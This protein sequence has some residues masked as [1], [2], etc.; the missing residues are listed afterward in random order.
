MKNI[1][2]GFLFFCL[3]FSQTLA[4]AK[5]TSQS[6]ASPLRRS[7]AQKNNAFAVDLYKK[8]A[9]KGGN[10]FFSP[11]SIYDALAM[12]F[13]G[14]RGRTEA[15]MARVLHITSP[16]EVFHPAFSSL[17]NVI[18]A[19]P[20]EKAY[21]LH[22][23]NALWG[24]KGYR[25]LP[26][27]LTLVNK[28]YD[29]GFH[30]VDFV[31][32]KAGTMKRINRWVEK[33]T[34][35]KIKDLIRN[36]DINFL[37]RLVLTNAIYF[38]GRWATRFKK[39]NTRSA[40]FYLSGGEKTDVPMMSQKGRFPYFE[41]KSLQVLELP[42]TGNDLSMVIFL[43]KNPVNLRKIGT[44]LSVSKLRTFLSRLQ[45]RRVAVTLPRFRLK[46]RY[47]LGPI[48]GSMGMPNAFSPVADFSGMSGNKELKIAKV[49][50]QAYV[51]VNE[52]G[53]EAAA[54]TAVVIRLKAMIRNPVFRADHPFLF[55]MIHKKTNCILFMGRVMNPTK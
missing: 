42:Y 23:A 30:L 18:K 10:I 24:Q 49:I 29:G 50:H 51:D 43:P 16:Q 34:G 26:N 14:A 37:T 39:E 52:E 1:I 11:F 5:T 12:T 38:K 35:N 20:V 25:F 41:D 36:G 47:Y 45:K 40:P 6:Q 22:I 21:K 27:F 13:A 44:Q 3:I 53:T 46:T 55:A 48:L 4:E 19:T 2:S 31:H 28:Y 8:L 15:Q 9:Q 32:D 33:K 7:M 54:A 17:I